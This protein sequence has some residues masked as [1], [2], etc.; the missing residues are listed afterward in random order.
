[1][2]PHAL[3]DREKIDKE[4]KSSLSMRLQMILS[5]LRKDPIANPPPFK[6]LTGPWD[7]LYARRLNSEHCVIYRVFEDCDSVMVVCMW[8]HQGTAA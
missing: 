6:R 4:E 1:M 3:A 5:Q 8:N 7:G 2:T